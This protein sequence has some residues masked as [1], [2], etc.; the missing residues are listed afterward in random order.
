MENKKRLVIIMN[1]LKENSNEQHK[2]NSEEIMNYLN[3]EYGI[4]SNRKTIY[5]DIQSLISLGFN[6][7]KGYHG[8]FWDD[9]IFDVTEL[10]ILT[11]AIRSAGFLSL[12][13]TQMM[14]DKIGDL[15]NKYDRQLVKEGS[16]LNVKTDNEQVLYNIYTILKAINGKQAITFSYFDIG[17]DKEKIFRDHDYNVFPL[18]LLVNHGRYYMVCYSEKYDSLSNYRVD[19]M[20][21]V[22][23]LE[24]YIDKVDFDVNEYMQQTFGMFSTEKRNVELKCDRSLIDEIYARFGENVI[25]T[26]IDGNDY[27]F[28]VD[29]SASEPF[30]GWLFA[31]NGKIKIISPKEMKEEFVDMCKK[32]I[33][34]HK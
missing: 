5:S 19:K 18:D 28:N 16:Y 4:T 33:E 12:K 8:F 31:Y 22:E 9:N 32:A 10:R 26:D 7:E 23:T 14:I 1:Y 27:Y 2:V 21:K 20:E 3:K 30:Y 29:I 13:K 24:K 15:C 34:L 25:I 6:I 17:I 11:D